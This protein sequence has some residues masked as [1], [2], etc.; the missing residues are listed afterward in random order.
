M[1]EAEH[2][3]GPLGHTLT[4]SVLKIAFDEAYQ[5]ISEATARATPP[6]E[7]SIYGAALWLALAQRGAD[8]VELDRTIDR[9]PMIA[10]GDQ[11]QVAEFAATVCRWA[12]KGAPNRGMAARRAKEILI[13]SGWKPGQVNSSFVTLNNAM[14]I[15]GSTQDFLG[16]EPELDALEQRPLSPRQ[17]AAVAYMKANSPF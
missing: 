14:H 17:R 16:G 11:G 15:F 8:P 4:P 1:N 10:F 6:G 13:R 2:I 9:L 5:A 3:R 12:H 7:A